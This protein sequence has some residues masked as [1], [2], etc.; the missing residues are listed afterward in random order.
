MTQ[1]SRW[2]TYA[3]LVESAD[4]PGSAW[5]V[6][7]P[8]DELGTINFITDEVRRRAAGLIRTGRM[9]NLDYSVSAF[10][11]YPTGTRPVSRHQLF[12]NNP[13]HFDDW[14]DSFYLQSTTQID[15]LRHIAHPGIGFY[16]GHQRSEITPDSPTL[17]IQRW[18]EI[19]GI[20]GRGI[21]LDVERHLA[22][23][24]RPIDQA[25]TTYITVGDLEATA[26]AHGVRFE[27][28]DILLLRT[29]WAEYC[30]TGMDAAAREAFKHDI[31]LPG[32][33]CTR[34]MVAWLWDHHFS[35]VAADNLGVEAFPYT[36]GNDLALPDQPRPEKG[37]DHNGS[38]HRPLIPLLGLALGEMWALD[39]LAADC[40]AD[41]VYEFFL[42]AKPLNVIGGVGSTANAV[43]IK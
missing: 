33:D 27:D 10:E 38:L 35:L 19:G 2:P 41:G 37:I 28:G 32:L 5:H 3:E 24:G 4:P 36:P 29:G 23:A 25:A 30:R 40:A 20:V 12:S 18:A 1:N 16:N 22:S 26:A 7:G 39:E 9:F 13:H 8:D 42:S 15:S 21:L 14:L 34:D 11:P 43:A 17:G 6:F 31:K